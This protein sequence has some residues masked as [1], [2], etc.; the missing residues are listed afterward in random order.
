MGIKIT[1]L[2]RIIKDLFLGKTVHIIILIIISSC[3]FFQN[4][5]NQTVLLLMIT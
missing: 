2:T 3:Y 1:Y 4:V 5:V